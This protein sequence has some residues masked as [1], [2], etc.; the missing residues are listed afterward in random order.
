MPLP[1]PDGRFFWLV[2]KGGEGKPAVGEPHSFCIF[3]EYLICRFHQGALVLAGSL[4]TG[5]FNA[6]QND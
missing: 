4:P 1:T 3:G 6:V 2:R 5:F